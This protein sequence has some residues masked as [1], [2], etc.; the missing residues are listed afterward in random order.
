MSGKP[1]PAPGSQ[2][3][4]ALAALPP[5]AGGPAPVARTEDADGNGA[6][7]VRI[8]FWICRHGVIGR[9][10]GGTVLAEATEAEAGASIPQLPASQVSERSSGKGT[11]SG[12]Q[13][14]PVRRVLNPDSMGRSILASG[15]E[16]I[17]F[18][19]MGT[20]PRW[21]SRGS[22]SRSTWSRPLRCPREGFISGI[23]L[24][25]LVA[26]ERSFLAM[27][28]PWGAVIFEGEKC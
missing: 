23:V 10:P 1:L 8:R 11:G 12:P 4:G 6:G 2:R 25:Y 19:A 17:E 28:H 15:Q 22:N 21:P 24:Q 9:L 18:R 13:W 5:P 20:R 27:L 16:A 7:T 14:D 3:H 26:A